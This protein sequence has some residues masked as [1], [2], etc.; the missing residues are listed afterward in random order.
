[1]ASRTLGQSEKSSV[2]FQQVALPDNS[3]NFVLAN[4]LAKGT[5]YE[6]VIKGA[7]RTGLAEGIG[8]TLP[9]ENLSLEMTPGQTLRMEAIMKR[10]GKTMEDLRT[11]FKNILDHAIT[12]LE[13]ETEGDRGIGQ[14]WEH[15]EVALPS[16]T[17]EMLAE[18]A[19]LLGISTSVLID[20]FLKDQNREGAMNERVNE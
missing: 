4:A 2:I 9:K 18:R 17:V 3:M 12:N 10:T 1:M 19:E 20:R 6:A 13:F 14:H 8:S 7:I 5:H 15:S 11:A 16:L